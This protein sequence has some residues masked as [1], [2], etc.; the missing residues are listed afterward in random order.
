MLFIRHKE[1]KPSFNF[2]QLSQVT[3]NQIQNIIY[4]PL[5]ILLP[6]SQII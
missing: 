6:V 2:W 4:G 3:L 1:A 5:I